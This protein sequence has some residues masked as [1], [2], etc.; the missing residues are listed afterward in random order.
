V[1]EKNTKIMCPYCKE[2]SGRKVGVNATVTGGKKQRYS[3]RE[4]GRSWY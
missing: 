4:C 2:M 3:C 1:T